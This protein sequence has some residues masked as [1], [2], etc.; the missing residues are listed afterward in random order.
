MLINV[1]LN[2]VVLY[3]VYS[4]SP[5]RWDLIL[6]TGEN[7]IYIAPLGERAGFKDIPWRFTLTPS[8]GGGPFHVFEIEEKT[9]CEGKENMHKH[10]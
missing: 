9:S 7:F 10:G 8:I 6:V 5:P 2:V 1:N 4:R 3:A